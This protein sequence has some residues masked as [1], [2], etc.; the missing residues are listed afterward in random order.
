MYFVINE[1]SKVTNVLTVLEKSYG[2]IYN[3]EE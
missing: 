3:E 1:V 2:Y